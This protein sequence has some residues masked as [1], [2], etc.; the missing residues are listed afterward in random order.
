MKVVAVYSVK[1]GVG[2]TTTAVNLA[3]EAAKSYRVLL[4]DLDPQAAS[5]WLLD[6]RPKLKGG[7]E[8]LIRGKTKIGQVVRETGYA[9]LDVLPADDSYRDLELALDQTKHSTRRL[10][11]L[12]GPLA[13]K[14]DVVILDCPPGESLL[15]HNVI[16]AADVIVLPLQPSPL[17]ARS[18]QQVRDVVRS[19]KKPPRIIGF[20]SMADRRKTGHRAAIADLPATGEGDDGDRGAEHDLRGAHGCG[21]GAPR[22]VCAAHGGRRGIRGTLGRDRLPAEADHAQAPLSGPTRHRAP[23]CPPLDSPHACGRNPERHHRSPRHGGADPE[24]ARRD[25]GA[26]RRGLRRQGSPARRRPKGA[27]MVMADFARA[28]PTAMEMDWMAVSSYGTGTKSSGV[29]QIRKDLDSDIHGRHVL[30]VEDIIDSGL[31]LSW[32]LENFA[33]RGAASVEVFA[34]LRKPDAAKVHVECRYI[35]FDIPNEFVIGYGLDFAEKYR[36]LRDV[37]VLAPHV[38][39]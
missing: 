35:G 22:C 27:V 9:N 34:L 14:Y 26:G 8:A 4:W 18:L 29:V 21:A 6:V 28:L 25:R 11:L 13:R 10:A 7:A 20:I 1:G 36:N 37:A 19:E 12:L 30:I 15:A 5:T 38:Y 33:S 24:Q 2:K 23:R 31:T 17:S 32:L 39:S 16:T 3:W